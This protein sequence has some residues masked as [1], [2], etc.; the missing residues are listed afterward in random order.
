MHIFIHGKIFHAKDE[1]KRRIYKKWARYGD[2]FGLLVIAFNSILYTVYN[3][4]TRVARL[5]EEALAA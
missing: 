1:N 2:E 5:S 3:V 4:I